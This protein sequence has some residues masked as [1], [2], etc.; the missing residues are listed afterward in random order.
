MDGFPARYVLGYLPGPLDQHTLI[1]QVT[2][3]QR[4]AWVEVYF[5]SYGWIPFD[6]TGGSVGQPTELPAGS[7][8]KASPSP[9]SSDLE[10]RRTVAPHVTPQNGGGGSTTGSTANGGPGGM[11]LPA[12]ISFVVLLALILLWQR[13][14]RRLQAPNTVY[15]GVVKLASRLG[16]KP[17]PAQTVYEYTGMLADLMPRARDS[18]GIVATAEVE[19][20][21][22]RRHLNTDRLVSLAAA[23]RRVRQALLRLVFRIPGR[24][25]K[26][27]KKSRARRR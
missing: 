1:E 7:E 2:A 15:R 22:G 18:L 11:L 23:Q 14:R 16:Y 10:S 3:Q 12:V 27:P 20:T 24:G 8:V 25:P 21:Y 17:L 19:V 5:P 9:S 26:P 6:P 13:R 4:H